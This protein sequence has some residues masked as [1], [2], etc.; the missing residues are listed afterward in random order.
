MN[1]LKTKIVL[2]ALVSLTAL[3]F[4]ADA[5]RA[6]LKPSATVL[7]GDA[8]F[9]TVDAAISNTLFHA[10]HHAMSLNGVEV[11]APNGTS[12]ELLNSSSGKYRSVFDL[13]LTQQGTYRIASASA[14]LRAFWRD[15]EGNRKMWPGR[16]QQANESE[17]ATAVPQNADELR[18]MRSSRRIESFAT[19]GAP[20]YE[21][22]EPTGH[23]LELAFHTHPN[24]LY[25]T[26]T[27]TFQFFIDGEPAAG[28]EVEVVRGGMRYRNS[29]EEITLV[30]N[31][32]GMVEVT[33]PE[34][35]MYFMEA[36]YQDDQAAAPATI[37]SGG[38][39]GTFEVLPL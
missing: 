36:S 29:Q 24:D 4:P 5:H 26:E 9:I 28:V 2:G 32:E 35:G 13:E 18:V 33:W 17:F 8:P 19:V 3:S 25:A 39:A 38:Y 21:V 6:W 31:A 23:G 37:R 1:N 27:A 12:L 22:L 34:A 11:T 10:D 30:S 20:T 7:S 15:E 14:G 16:G